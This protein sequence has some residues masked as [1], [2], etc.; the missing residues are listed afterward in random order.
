MLVDLDDQG[1]FCEPGGFYVD[2][3]GP[4]E[5]AVITHAH[6]DHA[7]P[8]ARSYLAAA[9]G[10]ALLRARLGPGAA[11]EALEYGRTVAIGGV[12]VSLH[13][14][15]HIPGSAQVRIEH[16]GEVWV[17]SGDY[18]LEADPT[19]TPFEPVRCHT[20]FTEAAFGLPIY[21]WPRQ[22]EVMEEINA[23]WRANQQSG[24]ASILFAFAPGMAQR[25]LAGI[26]PSTGPIFTHDAV[27]SV[28]EIYRR[29]GVALPRTV[30][31]RQAPAAADWSRAL[32]L[33]PPMSA[34]SGWLRRFG[35]LSTAFASGWMRIRGTRRRRSLDRGFVLSG[36]ADW[37]HLMS[38]IEATG[39]EHI[40]V[41]HGYRA[42]VVQWLREKGLDA[43]AV[44][45]RFDSE[46]DEISGEAM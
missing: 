43:E 17:I 3:W 12:G 26:D 39:A 27:E 11:I 44:E 29:C 18:K 35:S 8:G 9:S 37:P 23:W 31:V 36:H 33:A 6:S 25:V 1:L 28:N 20:F 30:D 13:P 46:W 21:R 22:A 38:A 34:A 24:K 32:I 41:T 40:R 16:R 7:R 2:P 19:C 5:R 10:E 4:V 42:P 45:T 15:G 14:A